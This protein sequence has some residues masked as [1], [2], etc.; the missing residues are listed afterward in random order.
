M[1]AHVS[2]HSICICSLL[3]LTPLALCHPSTA[4]PDPS[5]SS[6]WKRWRAPTLCTTRTTSIRR[7][8]PKEAAWQSCLWFRRA[9][10]RK[11]TRSSSKLCRRSLRR[12]CRQSMSP[13]LM[14][15]STSQPSRTL[16]G[17][18]FRNLRAA[19]C[20]SNRASLWGG[21]DCKRRCVLISMWQAP[22]SRGPQDG[23][24]SRC[25]WLFFGV[26]KSTPSPLSLA[27]AGR[28]KCFLRAKYTPLP[29]SLAGARK[30]AKETQLERE[31]GGG[32]DAG[33]CRLKRPPKQSLKK[34]VK[35]HAGNHPLTV[36]IYIYIWTINNIY[37][38]L[39]S[40]VRLHR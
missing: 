24:H 21:W 12:T 36:Y 13:W 35:T 20:Y 17:K 2:T 25:R 1:L 18:V 19:N 39:W 26:E 22:A 31:T 30:C 23:T 27:G 34:H 37:I 6:P 14:G 29:L 40:V 38:Y 15:S 7:W 5:W 16:C 9:A 4:S 32:K 8:R 28:C 33:G 11:T 3:A 10:P